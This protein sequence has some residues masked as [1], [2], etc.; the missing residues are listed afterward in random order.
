MFSRLQFSLQLLFGLFD[1]FVHLLSLL[2]LHLVQSLPARRVLKLKGSRLSEAWLLLSLPEVQKTNPDKFSS[3][4]HKNL[5]GL[6]ENIFTHL[7]Y[8]GV[9]CSNFSGR[10]SSSPSCSM[11][12]TMA[13]QGVLKDEMTTKL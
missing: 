2:F 12:S 8:L 6:E 1:V 10:P 4:G 7:W 9:F 13:G 5:Q 11:G 3:T